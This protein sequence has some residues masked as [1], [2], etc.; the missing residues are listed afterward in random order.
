MS[1]D[2]RVTFTVIKFVDVLVIKINDHATIKVHVYINNYCSS[3]PK[4]TGY[5]THSIDKITVNHI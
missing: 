3:N 2:R 1:I 5:F 4:T